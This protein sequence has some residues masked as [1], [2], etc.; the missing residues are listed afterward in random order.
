MANYQS[1]EELIKIDSP[2]GFTEKADQYVYN[3]LYSLGYQPAYTRKG[4]VKCNL[5][6]NPKLVIAAH[7]D[8]LGA[9]VSEI[10][11][12]GSLAFSLVGSP[13]L[14][15]IEGEHVRIYTIHD[16]V[17]SGTVLLKNPSKH[18]NKDLTTITRSN[19]NMFIRLDEEIKNKQDTT[20]LGIRPGDFVCLETHYQELDNGFIKS[21]FLDNKAGCFVL[22]ELAKRLKGN[23]K[24]IPVELFFSNYEEVGHG[25]AGGFV[26]SIEEMLVIDMG[27][28]GKGVVGD[29]YSC[30]VC[31][32]DTSGPYDYTMRKNL[33]KLAEAN[34]I[35]YQVSVYPY[36]SSDG[37][38]A[39]RAGNQFRVALIG[40]GVSASH[41]SERT[42]KKAIEATI[43]LCLAYINSKI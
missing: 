7:V 16:K 10:N 22:F 23:E 43:D 30:S 11:P 41:G 21:R 36:Y 19:E 8:T 34:R 15:D 12:D 3:L 26:D 17:F 24:N 39:W 13:S 4:A 2:S 28:V 9:I 20:A 42:H 37:T 25:A 5:G 40:Q 29:E 18:A 1:L 27:V 32:K 33:V 31:A 14:N 35:P 6:Q 38:A